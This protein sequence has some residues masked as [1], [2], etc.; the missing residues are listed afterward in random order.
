M[1]NRNNAATCYFLDVGQGTS[2]VIILNGHHAIIIDTGQRCK[3]T[4]PL[5]ALLKNFT[6]QTIEV[7]ILSH[8]DSDH[9]G[10]IENILAPHQEQIRRV[11][12]YL[13]T[14]NANPTAILL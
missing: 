11:F 3:E 4:N 12:I 5:L 7:L 9:I 14:Q 1:S 13:S 6:I 2:Q 8:N 10:D